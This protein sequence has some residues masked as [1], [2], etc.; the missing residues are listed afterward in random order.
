MLMAQHGVW[1]LMHTH[2][3]FIVLSQY[4]LASYLMRSLLPLLSVKLFFSAILDI[5]KREI[6]YQSSI[7][8][9]YMKMK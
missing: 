3:S 1:N 7:L 8:L 9:I 5:M 4:V 6:H 2:D